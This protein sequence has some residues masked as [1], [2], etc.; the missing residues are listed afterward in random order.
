MSIEVFE[1]TNASMPKIKPFCVFCG[2]KRKILISFTENDIKKCEHILEIRQRNNLPSKNVKVPLEL[3]DIE[4][5]HSKCYKKFSILPPEYRE[6]AAA[7]GYV[8][9][10]KFLTFMLI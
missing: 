4:Q 8:K 1:Q 7:S 6:T 10:Y 9:D 3:N 5:Y 2:S